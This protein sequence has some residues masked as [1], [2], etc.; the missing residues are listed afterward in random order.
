MLWINSEHFLYSPHYK[1][2]VSEFDSKSNGFSISTGKCWTLKTSK[3]D[4][5]NPGPIYETQYLGSV[6]RKV[7]KTI[8]L[9]RS[10]FGAYREKQRTIPNKGFEKAYLGVNSPGP[11][12]YGSME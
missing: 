5:T 9:K 3:R 8:Q 4:E 2:E 6:T 11:T 10:S 7:E 1:A 12:I